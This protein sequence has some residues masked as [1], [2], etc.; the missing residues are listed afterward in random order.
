MRDE[1]QESPQSSPPVAGDPHLAAGTEEGRNP[2]GER[3]TRHAALESRQPAALDTS[4]VAPP[5]ELARDGWAARAR[6]RRKEGRFASATHEGAEISP[7]EEAPSAPTQARL[8]RVISR[9]HGNLTV[10]LENCRKE[11][12]ANIARTLECLGVGSLHLVY[13]STQEINSRGFGRLDD[14]LKAAKLSRLSKS[15]SDWL[16]LRLHPSMCACEAALRAEGCE[17]LVATTPA[18]EGATSLYSA[19]SLGWASRS[20]A[21]LFGCEGSGLSEEAFGAADVRVSVPMRGMTQ[22]LNVAA[23]A[24][25]VLGEVLRLRLDA[26]ADPP[27]LT[28]EQQQALEDELLPTGGS[29]LRMHNKATVKAARR[30]ETPREVT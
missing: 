8:R 17:L 10:V 27:A 9:R 24:T 4:A 3:D 16:S 23:C 15:A 1:Q 18:A 14:E 6:R 25:L 2:P 26:H 11:N 13:T 21:L 28:L 7:A 20:C 12:V 22:S 30:A 5:P 29:P 19:A